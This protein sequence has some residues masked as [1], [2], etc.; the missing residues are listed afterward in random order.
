MSSLAI[1]GIILKAIVLIPFFVTATFLLMLAKNPAKLGNF[2]FTEKAG[3]V[4]RF[5]TGL[6]MLYVFVFESS[7]AAWIWGILYACA[8]LVYIFMIGSGASSISDKFVRGS[9]LITADQLRKQIAKKQPGT[10]EAITIGGVPIP[11]ELETQMIFVGGTTGAG[12]TQAIN[13]IL[14]TAR[15]R[16]NKAII[17][18]TGC[19]FWT[20]FGMAGDR[21]LNPF[22]SRTANWSPFA[23]IKVDYDCPRLAKAAIPDGTGD[24]GEWHHY[25][26]TLLAEVM[27]AMWQAGEHSVTRLLHFLTGATSEELARLLA[28]T[29]AAILCE[30]GNEKM[31]SNT[32]GIISTYLGTWRYLKDG[33]TFSVRQWVRDESND[34]WLFL[35]Y[36]DEQLAMLR[37]LVTTWIE[38][39]VIEG[40]SL[41]ENSSRRLFY[42]MDELDTLGKMSALRDG[43][44]KLRKYGGVV[45]AGLQTI[46]QLRDT[47]GHDGAQ[48]LLSCFSTKI[49]YRAG[50]NETAK[51][52]EGEL[53]QQEIERTTTGTSNSNSGNSTSTNIS[54]VTHDTVMASEIMNLENLHGYL[55]IPGYDVAAFNMPY[56]GMDDVN[57]P[58]EP[59]Q[60]PAKAVAGF[61]MAD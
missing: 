2:S 6:F 45:V 41:S 40:L 7:Q 12:K 53:G 1:L 4:I 46:A 26:Q 16:K 48:T 8:S 39:A 33:G 55:R 20:R 30:K 31:L 15:K 28:G 29:P 14:R 22:D 47:W 34:G 5:L 57:K 25:A 36:K 27:M 42:V 24:A 13:A 38:I 58:F 56:L 10:T 11:V 60:R 54:R 21:L 9:F 17:A 37:S 32:R 23:E 43:V 19:G 59:A 35:T 44:T 61:A 18:D 52:F 50:D 3:F 51:Y 49:I